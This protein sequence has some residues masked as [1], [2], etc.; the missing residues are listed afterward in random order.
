VPYGI[1]AP[2][3]A[4]LIF[5]SPMD[6]A[7]AL[8]IVLLLAVGLPLLIYRHGKKVGKAEG[9]MRGYKEGQDSAKK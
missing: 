6:I 5:D 4:A 3:L 1:L 8:G 2:V 9:Y 7:I